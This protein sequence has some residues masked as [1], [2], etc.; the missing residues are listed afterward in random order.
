MIVDMHCDTLSRIRGI[1]KA[2]G[3]GSLRTEQEL[4]CSLDKLKKGGYMLQNYAVYIDLKEYPDP[5]ANAMELVDIF[6]K[7][8]EE[9]QDLV[10]PVCTAA[11]IEAAW[12]SGK[13]SAMLTLEEGG[14]CCGEI[15]KLRTFYEKGAR[16]MA[17]LWNY[18]NE[19]GHPAAASPERENEK[20][21][22]THGLT[23]AGFDFV[24]E[25]ERIGMIIDV[26][27]LSDDG[28]FDV[29]EHTK[30][31][32][33]ASHS[34]A[35]ALCAHKRNLNDRMLE[36]CG[37]RGCVAGLNYYPEFL[38]EHL[39]KEA[40]LKKLA[41]HAVYMIA[42]A[43]SESVGLGSDFDGFSGEGRPEHAAQ[44]EDLIWAFHKAGISDDGIDR[45]LYENVMR[46]YREVLK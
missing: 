9:N 12:N 26:S 7:E 15:Q 29:Y 34:N 25:M 31:P 13:L 11:E 39:E 22:R 20:Q 3:T 5:Y 32:F 43:G 38:A 27:H 19:L 4:C 1:R 40:C 6:E 14:M 28:F 23:A 18:E 41:E 16:M 24:A 36:L 33:V 37:E 17:L 10:L 30:L 21:K 2:G 44:L 42:H 45:I 8:M 46:L 35:R